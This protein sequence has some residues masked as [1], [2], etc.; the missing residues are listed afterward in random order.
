MNDYAAQIQKALAAHGAWKQRLAAAIAAR[1]SGFTVEH[2]Q[3]DNRCEFG[4]WFY[5]LPLPVRSS[6]LAL[7]VQQLHA[8]FHHEAARVLGLALHGDSTVAYAA[9]GPSAKYSLISG[10]LTLA[11][12][13][14]TEDLPKL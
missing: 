14:W 11:M 3:V 13:Q 6:S 9:L 8:D 7:A 5:A 4:R 12:H 2:V 10:Q 1:D